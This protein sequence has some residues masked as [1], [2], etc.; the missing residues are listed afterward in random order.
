ME[1]AFPSHKQQEGLAH[2]RKQEKN[3]PSKNNHS[4][5]EDALVYGLENLEKIPASQRLQWYFSCLLRQSGRCQLVLSRIR[6]NAQGDTLCHNRAI[7]HNELEQVLLED[8]NEA[9][10][11]KPRLQFVYLNLYHL[12]EHCFKIHSQLFDSNDKNTKRK[13][14]F[15]LL[16]YQS[17]TDNFAVFQEEEDTDNADNTFDFLWIHW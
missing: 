12:I 1:I 17:Q 7:P 6:F 15:F 8:E 11:L 10:D 2:K 5:N 14:N 9:L 16:A 3:K 13:D 4:L